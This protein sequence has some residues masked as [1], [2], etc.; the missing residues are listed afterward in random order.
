MK[1]WTSLGVRE[2]RLLIAMSIV[3]GIAVVYLLAFEPAWNGRK[4]LAN[5]LPL[6]RQEVAQVDG[7]AGEIKRTSAQVLTSAPLRGLRDELQRSLERAGLKAASLTGNDDAVEVKLNGV[8]FQDVLAWQQS[9]Q[10]DLRLKTV[11]FSVARDTKAGA[12]S[13]QASF[14]TP[15]KG[16]R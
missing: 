8:S 1:F 11:R 10:K 5:T 2:R 4:K 15:R 7:L 16:E 13:V 12:V 6:L 9:V 14:E 3:L